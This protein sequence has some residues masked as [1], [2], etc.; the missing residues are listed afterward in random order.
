MP[1][2]RW[3]GD[4]PEGPDTVT[5]NPGAGLGAGVR[6]AT[7]MSLKHPYQQVEELEQRIAEYRAVQRT[8][9]CMV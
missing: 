2:S 5:I 7:S 1:S 6:N 4:G 9:S 3:L 8:L